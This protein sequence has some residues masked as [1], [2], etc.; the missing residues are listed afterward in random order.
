MREFDRVGPKR[1]AKKMKLSTYGDM[2][3]EFNELLAK[4]QASSIASG[5]SPPTI[6]IISNWKF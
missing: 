4:A 6:G 1:E 3:R 5:L 2:Q